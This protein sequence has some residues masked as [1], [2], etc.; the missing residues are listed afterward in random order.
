MRPIIVMALLLSLTACTKDFSEINTNPNAPVSVYPSLLLR[1]VIYSYG[2][3]MS[4]EGFVAGNL[5]GQYFTAIDFN[6]FDRHSLNEPQFGG[7]PWP[8]LYTNLRDNELLLRQAQEQPALAVYE[9]PARILKAY[10]AA[11]LT[12]MFGDVP[13][14]EALRGTE[15]L[16]RPKYDTQEAIYLAPGGIL[17]NLNQGIA[18]IEAYQGNIRLEGDILFGGDLPAWVAFANSLKIKSLMRISGRMDVRAELQALYSGGNYLQSNAQNAAF[19]FTD[20]QPNNFR[21]ARLRS[22]DFNLFILSQ[23]MDEILSGLNDPRLAIWFRP[24]GNNP[25]QYRGLLNGPDA[26]QTSISVADYSLSGTVFREQTGRLDANFLTAWETLFWLAEAAERGWISADAK[27]LYD[28]AVTLAFEYWQTPMPAGYLSSGPAAYGHNG[29]DKLAQIITQ[30]WMAN[31][32]N[33]Y[34]GWIEWRRT[35]YPALK[36]IAASLNNGLIPVRMPYPAGEAALNNTNFA[37]AAAI[38]Q[39]NSINAPV[40]WDVD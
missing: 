9:G 24:T 37:A 35:G 1:Q 12:D 13:Y 34:E 20:G 26:S 19:D 22:G 31:I 15:G 30:K 33:G 7:N 4:Y 14:S 29:A 28:Q 23:T 21:M 40:W 32:I 16:V 10:M 11:A 2:E 17:D 27:L 5:L 36:P 8:V 38:T 39:G 6:L 3:E 25:A 18:A